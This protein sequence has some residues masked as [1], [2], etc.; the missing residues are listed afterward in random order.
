MLLLLPYCGLNIALPTLLSPSWYKHHNLAITTQSTPVPKSRIHPLHPPPLPAKTKEKK[1]THKN[2]KKPDRSFSVSAPRQA[3][4]TGDITNRLTCQPAS[5]PAYQPASLPACQ[6]TRHA[7]RQPV[8]LTAMLHVSLPASQ[9]VSQIACLPYH[10]AYR[11]LTDV[12]WCFM[13][14]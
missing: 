1:H 10:D 13:R 6:P 9:P 5:L 8:D 12:A 2:N 11:R 7:A 3:L 14:T 4:S